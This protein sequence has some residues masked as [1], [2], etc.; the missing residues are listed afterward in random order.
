MF[1]EVTAMRYPNAAQ[2]LRMMFF[3]QILMIVGVLLAWVPLVGALL[4]IAAPIAELVGVYK[5]GADDE[6]YRGALVFVALVLMVNFISG[7]KGEGFL[8][9]I[10]DMVSEVLNLMVVFSVCNTTSNLLHSIGQEELSQR[11]GTVIKIYAACTVISIVCQALG[12][13]PIIN[14]AAALVLAVSS[15]VQLV[16]YVMYLLFLNGSGK[17]L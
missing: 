7:F 4:I 5:A 3:G 13:I 12:F 9:S 15:I 17:A 8:G 6:N 10:L 14:I 11:G 16:G 1:E 2:G